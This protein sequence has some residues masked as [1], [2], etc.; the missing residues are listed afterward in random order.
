MAYSPFARIDF[1]N[2]DGGPG[3]SVLS[4]NQIQK[5]TNFAPLEKTSVGG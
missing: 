3:R 1:R 4:F 2:Q 5:K